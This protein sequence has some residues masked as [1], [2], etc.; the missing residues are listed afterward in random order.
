MGAEVP[1]VTDWILYLAAVLIII[2]YLLFPV[3]AVVVRLV[4]GWIR[5]RS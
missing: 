2:R 4:R 5:V 3:V 1:A